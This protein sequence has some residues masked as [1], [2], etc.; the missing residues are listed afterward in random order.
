MNVD[1]FV[2]TFHA[3][4][5]FRER[6]KALKGV[7]L[8]DAELKDKLKTLIANAKPEKDSPVLQLRREAHGGIGTYLMN[9][10]WRFVFSDKGLETCEIV[11]QEI[12]LV[13]NPHIPADLER[14]RFFIKIKI[15]KRKMLTRITRSLD[16]KTLHLRNLIE[17]NAIVRSLRVIGLEVNHPEEPNRLEIVV[18]RNIAS[19]R[20]EQ[21]IG[22]ENILISLGRTDLFALGLQRIKCLG[23]TKLELEKILDFLQINKS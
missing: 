4:E 7:E 8:S 19:Y 17:I 22:P 13:K 23:I 14:T 2:I 9:P 21:L 12:L 20:I 18:P 16:R 1:N 6:Y 11:P 10:P 15:K 5:R 3:S